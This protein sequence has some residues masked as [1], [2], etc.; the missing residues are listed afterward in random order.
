MGH[1]LFDNVGF[2]AAARALACERGPRAVT[3]DSVTQRLRAPKGSFYHRFASRD[4]LLGELWL[5]TVLA[6]QEGFVGAI[7]RGDGLAA[8]LHTPAWARLRLDDARLLLLY[9]RHDFVHGDWPAA[10]K[11][12]VREQAQQFESCLASF[13]RHAFG[14]AGPA[15]LRRA[16]FVLA[17]VPIAAVKAH[18]ERREPPPM[19]VDELITKTYQAIVGAVTRRNNV[20]PPPETAKAPH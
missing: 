10:L 3:V 18:L 8:A 2:L 6:Y 11:R 15:Q 19:L 12:G 20:G 16:T 14:R 5:K 17:E 9:S 13:A 4:A 7:E 1:A